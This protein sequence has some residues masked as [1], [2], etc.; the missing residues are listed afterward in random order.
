MMLESVKLSLR[1][2]AKW[3]LG[4]MENAYRI[5]P[6][7]SRQVR[8]HEGELAAWHE[9]EFANQRP[10]ASYRDASSNA[11]ELGMAGATASVAWRTGERLASE[12]VCEIERAVIWVTRPSSRRKRYAQERKA[13]VFNRY[14]RPVTCAGLP[15]L[16]VFLTSH[17]WRRCPGPNSRVA[18][19]AGRVAVLGN[20]GFDTK[21]YYHFWAD[22]MADLWFLRR[23]LPESRMPERYLIHFAGLPWQWEILEMCGIDREQVIPMLDH[24]FLKAE[25][26]LVPVRD[27]GAESLPAWLADAIRQVTGW[28]RPRAASSQ[29]IYIS[30]ADALRRRVT[31]EQEVCEHLREAGFRIL[32]LDGLSV[33]QQQV[34]F[35]SASVVC[36]PHGAALTNLVWCRPGTLVIDFLPSS[37][38]VPCFQELSRQSGVDY[39]P[40]ICPPSSSGGRSFEHDITIPMQDISAICHHLMSEGEAH[41]SSQ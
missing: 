16:W 4:A 19:L 13:I 38:L 32:T 29:R 21:N 6:S 22:A 25:T 3:A 15:H 31:N 17:D 26:V 10:D 37:Y 35:A 28:Q 41:V 27:K 39:L 40:V 11:L 30:R 5:D 33:E 36:A 2:S 7:S 9:G 23:Q 20:F 14:Y 34:L 1:R 8:W 12:G 24:E 18:H